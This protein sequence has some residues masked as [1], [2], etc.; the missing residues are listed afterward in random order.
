[1][2]ATEVAKP[3]P[4]L[5][6]APEEKRVT[7]ELSQTLTSGSPAGADT[8]LR[9]SA[10]HR[11]ALAAGENRESAKYRAALAAGENRE[12]ANYRAALAGGENR[13][14]AKYRAASV[15]GDTRPSG[16]LSLEVGYAVEFFSAE[17]PPLRPSEIEIEPELGPHSVRHVRTEQQLARQAYLRQLVLKLMLGAVVF[18]AIIAFM[19]WRRGLLHI[20]H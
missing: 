14:S 8:N 2:P 17:P 15:D 18:V 11:A 4:D 12:S 13:E 19:A 5:I 10:K 3:A 16:A 1:M 7:S 9:E 20:A 6:A